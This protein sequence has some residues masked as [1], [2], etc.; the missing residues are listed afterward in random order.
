MNIMKRTYITLTKRQVLAI[1]TL[2]KKK[3]IGQVAKKYGVSWQAVYYWVKILRERGIKIELRKRGKK[4]LLKKL[5]EQK[6]KK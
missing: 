1:P 3:S 5:V 4:P 2:L 6:L